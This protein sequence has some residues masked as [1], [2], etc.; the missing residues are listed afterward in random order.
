MSTLHEFRQLEKLTSNEGQ[1][2]VRNLCKIAKALGYKDP[3]YFGQFENGCYGDLIE[4][5]EDNSGLVEKMC[6]WIEEQVEDNPD[7]K[8]SLG[9]N[10]NEEDEED[11]D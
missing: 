5:L 11:R 9:G 2:G 10:S 8:E 3:M 7:W 4:L 6:E 1:T